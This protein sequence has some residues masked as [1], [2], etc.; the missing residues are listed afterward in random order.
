GVIDTRKM[1]HDVISA[2]RLEYLEA[3]F[4]EY[5]QQAFSLF[6]V[7]CREIFIIRLWR[8]QCTGSSLLQRRSR[9]N[10]QK[11][12]HFANSLCGLGRSK[13]PADPPSRNTVGFGHSIDDNRSLA[14]A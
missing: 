8:A 4:L 11:I 10:R 5:F 2:S 14:H 9:A 1:S 6:K 12:V 13:R 7:I 3:G